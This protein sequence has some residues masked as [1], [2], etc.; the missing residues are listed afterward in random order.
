MFSMHQMEKRIV[1]FYVDDCVDWYTS[2]ALVK[3]FVKTLGKRYH[4]NFLVYPHWFMSIRISQMK[5][6]YISIDQDRYATYI[7]SK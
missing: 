3:W 7:I 4:V 1:L 2:E 5:D 6:N